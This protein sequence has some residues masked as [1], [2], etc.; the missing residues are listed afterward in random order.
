MKCLP[1]GEE[2]TGQRGGG[3][4]DVWEDWLTPTTGG[5]GREEEVEEDE[6]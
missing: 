1:V 6:I 2:Q 4:C 5:I 3:L